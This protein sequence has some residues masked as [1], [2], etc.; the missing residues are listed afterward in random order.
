[1][2]AGNMP[3][4][5]WLGI[6]DVVIGSFLQE[7]AKIAFFLAMET[8][9]RAFLPPA[10]CNRDHFVDCRVPPWDFAVVI[11]ISQ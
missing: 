9:Q 4:Q 7:T 3:T 1:M 8:A 11:T 10:L 6:Y 5:K 2:H